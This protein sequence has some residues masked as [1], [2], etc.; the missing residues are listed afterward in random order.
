VLAAVQAGLLV[1]LC[2][3]GLDMHDAEAVCE[4]RHEVLSM[5]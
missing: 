3:M 5:Q 1:T 4:R 2:G